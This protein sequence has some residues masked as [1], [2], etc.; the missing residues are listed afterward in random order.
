MKTLAARI[1]PNPVL[2]KLGKKAAASSK[3]TRLEQLV[4]DLNECPDVIVG[5]RLALDEIAIELRF[6][7]EMRRAHLQRIAALEKRL[8]RARTPA[9]HGAKST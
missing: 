1:A 4:A 6:A 7:R 3:R 9:Q 8:E 5:V 2:P